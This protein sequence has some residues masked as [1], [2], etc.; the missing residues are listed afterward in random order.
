MAL[1]A[2]R[3]LVWPLLPLDPAFQDVVQV[4][5]AD[6]LLITEVEDG[7]VKEE[8]LTLP[9]TESAVVADKLFERGHLTGDGRLPGGS[10]NRLRRG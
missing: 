2:L 9:A 1:G 3:A 6:D 4:A 10:H 7:R 8:R 5:G